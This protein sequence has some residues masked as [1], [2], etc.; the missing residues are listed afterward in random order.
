VLLWTEV[1]FANKQKFKYKS[2]SKPTS[3]KKRIS[4]SNLRGVE[5][6]FEFFPQLPLSKFKRDAAFKEIKGSGMH[7]Q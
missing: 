6:M 1:V 4:S 7:M 2:K 3:T 5:E